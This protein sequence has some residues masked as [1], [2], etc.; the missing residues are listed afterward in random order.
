RQKEGRRWVADLFPAIWFMTSRVLRDCSPCQAKLIAQQGE[1]NPGVLPAQ[2][3]AVSGQI[4]PFHGS[5]QDT[6]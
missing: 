5:V 1:T 6:L 2:A 3:N 4:R